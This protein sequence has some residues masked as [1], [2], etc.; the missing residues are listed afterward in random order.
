MKTIITFIDRLIEAALAALMAVMTGVVFVGVLW[1]YV[2]LR[3]LGWTEEVGRFCL[4][5]AS[6]LG[7]YLAYRRFEHI[8]VDAI[9]NRM[10]PTIRM[11]LHVVSTCLMAVFLA[12]LTVEGF[13]YSSAF[14]NSQSAILGIPL[15]VVYL[16]LPI[17]GVL[18]LAAILIEL[19]TALRSGTTPEERRG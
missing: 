17:S 9:T 10:H 1:R 6:L 3:P 18:M 8:R 7:M 12:A 19:S 13:N 4:I 14:L 5:W 16:A 15:G 11:Q 2:L